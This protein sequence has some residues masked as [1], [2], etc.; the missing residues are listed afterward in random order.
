MKLLYL[1]C[2]GSLEYDEVSLFHEMGIQVF[3]PGAYLDPSKGEPM[4]RPGIPGLV[5]DPVD[6]E[7][8]HKVEQANKTGHD[9]KEFLSKELIDRFDVIVVMHTPQWVFK[10]WDIMR[11]KKV[12]WRAIGQS[13]PDLEVLLRNHVRGGLKLVRYSPAE[14]R[15]MN[16]AGEHA[17]I[18]FYKDHDVYKDWNGKEN[19]VIT[20]CQSIADRGEACRW[21]L[22]QEV[23][24]NLP[25]KVYGSSNQNV[26]S[27]WQGKVDFPELKQVMR[28]HRAYFS[29]G[30]RPASY[31]L[32]FVESWMTGIPMVAIGP[33]E[34]NYPGRALYEV[35][36][37][38]EN[39]VNGFCSDNPRELQDAIWHLLRDEN[40]A[41]KI[42]IAGRASA[43]HH[44]SKEQARA[45]W[46]T[47]FKSI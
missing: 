39:G 42:S 31:V 13:N 33:D 35:H 28:D 4:M 43:I 10:N 17:M 34:G 46:E 1:S 27:R 21:D 41:K 5:Y 15:L 40:L 2:H 16:Y 8:W 45:G 29:T 37:L 20:I 12:V 32:N 9:S 38:I 22:F 11:H 18:R 26:G 6:L 7:L 3:S 44:F 24:G 30:T 47:F 19:F 14:R 25:T 23:T 36:E